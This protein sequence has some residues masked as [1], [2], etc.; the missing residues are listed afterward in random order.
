[1]SLIGK[2]VSELEINAPAEKF[3]KIFKHQCFHVPNITPKFIQQV[4]IHD[5]NW[6]DHDHGSI[7]TWY[8]TVGMHKITFF[9]FFFLLVFIFMTNI[10]GKKID[11]FL[12]CI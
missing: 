1:M 8:Y 9:F 5:A 2:L 7:K 11:L 3:Y 6:D 12:S 4:E 10:E